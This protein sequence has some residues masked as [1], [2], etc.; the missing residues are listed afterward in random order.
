MTADYKLQQP[1]GSVVVGHSLFV[2]P[3]EGKGE[4][5]SWL[6]SVFQM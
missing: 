4:E 6:C 1:S 2:R 5:E 3:A